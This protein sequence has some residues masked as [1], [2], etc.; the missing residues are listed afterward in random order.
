MYLKI[1]LLCNICIYIIVCAMLGKIQ[2]CMSSILILSISVLRLQIWKFL[3]NV[4]KV[5]MSHPLISFCNNLKKKRQIQTNETKKKSSHS[6]L[7]DTIYIFGEHMF[8]YR[9]KIIPSKKIISL[10]EIKTTEKK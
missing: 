4:V 8:P 2:L 1:L 10:C 5:S 3:K 9:K 6:T 7:F